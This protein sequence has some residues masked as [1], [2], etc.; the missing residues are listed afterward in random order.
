[1]G[2]ILIRAMTHLTSAT[3]TEEELRMVLSSSSALEKVMDFR[4]V[5]GFYVRLTV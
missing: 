2:C 1:M 5:A 4:L 3:S